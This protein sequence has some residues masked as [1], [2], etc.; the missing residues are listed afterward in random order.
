MVGKGESDVMK[1]IGKSEGMGEEGMAGTSPSNPHPLI[2]SYSK[3]TKEQKR[4][5]KE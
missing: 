1:G 4:Q 5:Y 3:E 2:P